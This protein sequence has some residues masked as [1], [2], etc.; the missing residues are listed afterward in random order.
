M[1][2]CRRLRE[3]RGTERSCGTGRKAGDRRERAEAIVHASASVEARADG[4]AV[5]PDATERTR[6]PK[7]LR[8]GSGKRRARPRFADASV[9]RFPPPERSDQGTISEGDPEERQDQRGRG[10]AGV[11]MDEEEARLRIRLLSRLR[12]VCDIRTGTR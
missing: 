11:R 7:D 9:S 1:S 2:F 10:A 6:D 4:V 5:L 12:P 3:N 8:A